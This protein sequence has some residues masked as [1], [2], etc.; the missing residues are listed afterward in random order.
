MNAEHE[1][2]P[3]GKRADILEAAQKVFLREG[4]ALASMETIAQEAGVSKQTVYNHFGGKEELF[5]AFVQARCQALSGALERGILDGNDALERTLSDFGANVLD[6]MLSRDAMRLKR[7]LQSEGRR[8]PKL[9][10]IFYRQGPDCTADRLSR[11]LA[12]QNEQGRLAVREPR[13]AAEQ[14]VAMLAGHLRM[15]HL[16]GLAGAPTR[17]ERQRYV[18]NAVQLFLD[19]ARRRD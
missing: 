12:R 3:H 17:A 19:G 8:H 14:F 2:D 13:I 4:F 5:R 16:I 10:E 7:L 18:A 1:S 15:R 11:Y 6:V 9:A